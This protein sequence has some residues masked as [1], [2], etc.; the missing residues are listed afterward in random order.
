M[1]DSCAQGGKPGIKE[2]G[3]PEDVPRTAA[4][5]HA[6]G[7]K[8]A[9][10]D[11]MGALLRLELHGFPHPVAELAATAEDYRAGLVP[12][13]F[14]ITVHFFPSNVYEAAA[15]PSLP[16]LRNIERLVRLILSETFFTSELEM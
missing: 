9:P 6:A 12:A 14:K 16:L 11:V 7:I 2:T 4:I 1:G 8:K 3:T 13:T 10:A 5:T 15:N